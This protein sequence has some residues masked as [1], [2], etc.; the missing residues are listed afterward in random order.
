MRAEREARVRVTETR[1][2]I[3][4]GIFDPIHYA[5]LAIAE[6]T[7]EALDLAGVLF[8]PA[9]QPV[10]R[11]P[12]EASAA[13]RL[14]MVELATADNPTFEVSALEVQSN[15]PSYSVDTLERLTA[16]RPDDRFVFIMSA[17]AAIGLPRWRDPLRLLEL[18]EVAIVPRLGYQAVSRDWLDEVFPGR[19]DRFKFIDASHLGHSAS[20]VRAR[21][22]RG[23]SIRYLVPPAVEA[24]ITDH[25]LYMEQEPDGSD[26]R[27]AA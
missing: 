2:G 3:L 13:D 4:G 8:L 20:E 21:R 15:G 23:K 11:S 22:A 14:K 6:Q 10:H 7:R 25:N 17:E 12:A 9:G 5:H 16:E 24:Y 19:G 26:D 27:P 18:A 1:W